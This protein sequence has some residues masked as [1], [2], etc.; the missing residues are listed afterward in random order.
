ML[1]MSKSYR[2]WTP[3]QAYLLPPSPTEWLDEGHLAYFVL[4]V[5]P[6]LD[7]SAIERAIQAKDGRGE[8][9]YAPTMMVVLLIYAYCVGVFSSRKMA[10]ATYEDVAFRVIAGEE[11]PHFTT[12]NQFRLEHRE[13][14]AAL[15]VQVLK[16]CRK[17]GLV[18]LGHVS[19]DGTKVQANASKHKAMSY[20]RMYEEEKRLEGEVKALL[21]RADET[22][23]REDQMYGAGQAAEDLP[24]EMRRRE[25]RLARIRAAKTA[26]E[27]EAAQARLE[28]LHEQVTSQREKAADE[29]LSAGERGRAAYLAATAE[30]KAQKIARDDKDDGPGSA[31]GTGDDLPHHRVSTE[32]DGTPYPKAQRNFTDP[33]S[34]IMVKS[35][36]I[37]Q[38]YNA[39]TAVDAEAQ[40]IVAA[41]VTNQPPDQEHL[42]PMLDRV[43]ANCGQAPK[44]ATADN[45]FLSK[46]NIDGCIE[47]SVDAYIAVGREPAQMAHPAQATATPAQDARRAMAAKLT[48]PAGKATYARRKAIVEPPFGHI[49]E[50]RGFRRFSL[51]GI[52]KVRCEWALLCLTHNLLKLFRYG[53]TAA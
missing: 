13:R 5:V 26:L 33:D 24:A 16:L 51:R 8:R 2:P 48:T 20:A 22:D 37:M 3:T 41:A 52:E 28:L 44:V 38:A 34:R 15:F 27:Q 23:R 4:D 53:P 32:V 50:A 43:I 29:S 1:A 17:A 35:G 21:A 42:I 30:Q 6:M 19:F 46:D 39:H 31:G 47:R 14:L 36:A 40:I 7:L 10:R 45:G 18:K 9:P 25:E 12:I 49:K 11:H